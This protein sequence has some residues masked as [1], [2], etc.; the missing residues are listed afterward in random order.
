M[1]I[2]PALT[3]WPPKRF[4]PKYWAL[5][6]RPLRELDAPFLCAM[7]VLP[8]SAGGRGGDAGDLDLRQRLAVPLALVV[9]GLVLELVD[10]DFRA[11]GVGH[12]FTGHGDGCQVGSR[13]GD[14]VAIDDEHSRERHGCAGFALELLDLDDVA[15]GDLVLLAAGLDDRVHR[16]RAFLN[17]SCAAV[18]FIAHR[19]LLGDTRWSVDRLPDRTAP[20]PADQISPTPR[21]RAMRTDVK[22]GDLK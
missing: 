1:R 2:S 19:G 12:D 8:L 4:T 5:E 16:G 14:G 17:C 18:V 13:R 20:D 11:L 22:P 21:C 7:S 15:L 6:S 9:P 3:T 10:D